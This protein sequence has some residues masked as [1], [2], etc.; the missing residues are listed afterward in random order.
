MVSVLSLHTPTEENRFKQKKRK[1]SKKLVSKETPMLA[2]DYLL[3][4]VHGSCLCVACVPWCAVITIVG[5]SSPG[6]TLCIDQEP[7]N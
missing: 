2:K 1:Q 3:Y 6:S 5:W 7:R 4:H